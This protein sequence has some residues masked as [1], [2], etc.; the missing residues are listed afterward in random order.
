[1]K[2]W[3]R[4]EAS[5]DSFVAE[6]EVLEG[7]FESFCDLSKDFEFTLS[8]RILSPVEDSACFLRRWLA[9]LGSMGLPSLLRQRE[10]ELC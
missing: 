8:E 1:M 2:W 6:L 7:D 3:A 4:N 9:I 10:S 5:G